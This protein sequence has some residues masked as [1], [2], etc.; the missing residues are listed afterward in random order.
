MSRKGFTLMEVMVAS[1]ITIIVM[2]SFMAVFIHAMKLWQQEEIKNELNYNLEEALEKIRQDLRLSSLTEYEKG[3]M[4]FYGATGASFRAISIPISIDTDGD[5]LL[6]T[7]T[8][9]LIEWNQTIIY[10]VRPGTPDKLMRTVFSPR[11]TNASAAEIYA[12]LANVVAATSDAQVLLCKIPSSDETGISSVVFENLV[13]LTFDT[14][15]LGSGFDCYS[16]TAGYTNYL[17]GSI[18]L[19]AGMHRI[20]FAVTNKNSAA[21]ATYKAIIDYVKCSVSGSARDAELFTFDASHPSGSYYTYSDTSSNNVF[22]EYMG[23]EWM[24]QSA[25]ILDKSGSATGGMVT[26][27]VTNDLWCDNNFNDPSYILAENCKVDVATNLSPQDVVVVPV[28]G[29]TWSASDSG[30]QNGATNIASFAVVT[31]YVYGMSNALGTLKLNGCWARFHFDRETNTASYSLLISNAAVSTEGGLLVSNITFG[32]SNWAMLYPESTNVAVSDWVPMWEIEKASN[33]LVRFETGETGDLD[34]DMAVG[35]FAL[36]TRVASYRNDGTPTLPSFVL[37]DIAWLNP[38]GSGVPVPYF[39]DLDADGDYDLTL[40]GGGLGGLQWYKNIGTSRNPSM[41]YIG[42]LTTI[43]SCQNGAAAFADLDGDGDLDCAFTHYHANYVTYLRNDGSPKSNKFVS[44]GNLVSG[45]PSTYLAPEFADIDGDGLFEMFAGNGTDGNIYY[46]DNTGT[47]NSPIFTLVTVTYLAV[48]HASKRTVP[49]FI[50]INGDG[51]LDLFLGAGAGG[52]A[53]D[54]EIWY[55]ENTGSPMA[56]AW[57]DPVT[58]T[59]LA[60]GYAY[61][62]F[63]N[64]DAAIGSYGNGPARWDGNAGD[65]FSTLDGVSKSSLIGLS[66]IE[67]GYPRFSKFRSGVFDTTKAA[68]AYHQ[69]NWTEEV[70]AGC[71]V[72]V[73]ARFSNLADMSD[74]DESDWV[75]EGGA[76]NYFQN[77]SDNTIPTGNSFRYV[78]YEAKLEVGKS[79]NTWAHTNDSPPMLRDVTI[80]WTWST[81][82]DKGSLCDLW[83]GLG[84][85][86]DC[87]IVSIT[88]DGQSPVKGIQAKMQIYKDGRTGTNYSSGI[89]EVWPLNTRK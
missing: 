19:S 10:H 79:G 15:T 37:E 30:S 60:A 2:G 14:P 86:P 9:G 46:W 42:K 63:A 43:C 77:N 54:G 72:Y 82:S 76:T 23:P 5:G 48:P 13:S 51:K 36:G 3:K 20:T 66:G 62:A 16:P 41:Q 89:M 12:Q 11:W 28:K 83:T 75:G 6:Q 67:V 47:T 55:Y 27:N 4:A 88:I 7:D 80:D 45:L 24:G 61:P 26:L 70:N 22:Y 68:P 33:Y 31:N 50:D 25:L 29:M 53:P 84:L 73:R 8:N 85:G 40:S 58:N 78:Q 32:G 71:D 87:G 56:P 39:A 64:I 59:T 65:T 69:V 81:N 49:R 35:N 57:A 38:G 21:T 18:I 44:A 1:A 74:V 17:W 34:Y 52:V